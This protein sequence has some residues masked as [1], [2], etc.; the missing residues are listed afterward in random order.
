MTLVKTVKQALF[1]TTAT[2]I[3]TTVMALCSLGEIRLNSEEIKKMEIYNQG[4]RWEPMDRKSQQE[5][6]WV[7]EQIWLN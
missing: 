6:S 7:R 5:T 1:K 3:G 2:E 4:V